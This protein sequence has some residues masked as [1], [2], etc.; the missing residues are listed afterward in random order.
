M[1]VSWDY[2]EL[3]R[4]LIVDLG[5]SDYESEVKAKRLFIWQGFAWNSTSINICDKI[6]VSESYIYMIF[7]ES[8]LVD[9][10]AV[11]HKLRR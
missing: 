7:T 5:R 9:V 11:H 8:Y 6:I 3:Y 4:M 10:Q 2:R 1:Q